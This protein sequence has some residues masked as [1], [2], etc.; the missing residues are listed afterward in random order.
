M[1][2]NAS[3]KW[4]S[5][6][7]GNSQTWGDAT[8]H[9]RTVADVNGDGKA[10]IVAFSC[11]GVEVALS[12]GSS[13]AS[14]TTWINTFGNSQTWGDAT[15]HI[16]TVADVNGDGKA[17]V[18][19]FSAGGV[20]VALSTGTSF[21]S[22]V[23]WISA[24]GNSQGWGSATDHIR[25]LADVNG[26]GKADI[27]AFADIGVEVALSNAVPPTIEPTFSPT[28][29]PS[30][31]N[32]TFA[33]EL[34]TISQKHLR[35]LVISGGGVRGYIPSLILEHISKL[36]GKEIPELFD[37]II[38]TSYISICLCSACSCWKFAKEQCKVHCCGSN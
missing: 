37:F 34:G 33:E 29:E 10:D 35:I 11:C 4:I 5:S 18:V 17:D 16:R 13:F 24:F 38:G 3:T 20:E 7:F 22:P 36:A 2:F 8:G 6:T 30:Y 23:T 15:G 9:I 27:V 1:T 21:A 25:T 12:T 19:A 32:Y 31:N 26:D 14:P 28:T